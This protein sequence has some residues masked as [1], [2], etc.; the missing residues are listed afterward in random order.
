MRRVS[1]H[2]FV[3]VVTNYR[4]GDNLPE[5]LRLDRSEAFTTYYAPFEYINTAAK[6]VLCGITPGLQQA[7]IALVT[8]GSALRAG[9]NV[10]AALAQAKNTASF[11]G[12]MRS[13]LVAMLDH[14]GLPQRLGIHSAAELFGERSDLVHFT[15]ALRNPVFHRGENFSGTPSMLEQASLRWQVENCLAEEA[16]LL[17]GALWIPL[18]PKVSQALRHLVDRGVIDDAQVIDGLPHPSGA[19]AERVSV[20]L[21]R[22][23]PAAASA[24]TDASAILEARNRA[25]AKISGAHLKPVVHREMPIQQEVRIER[26]ARVPAAEHSKISQQAESL[27]AQQLTRTAP[28]TKYIAGFITPRQRQLAQERNRQSIS[29]WSEAVAHEAPSSLRRFLKE[30]YPASRTRNSN[31]NSKNADRLRVGKAVDYWCFDTLGDLG[32]FVD[33]YC[34]R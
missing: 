3:D 28:P 17:T 2:D 6:V 11:A 18:G 31:L 32:V 13:N 20:F 1:L 29:I 8:A 34:T 14:I 33:W 5:S 7:T 26:P 30:R 12:P 10:E 27:L 21:G 4:E 22:K 23:D 25:V 9:Q 15:S 24:K 16:A 19:N